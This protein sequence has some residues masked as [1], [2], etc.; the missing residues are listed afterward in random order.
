MVRGVLGALDVRYNELDIPSQQ[1]RSQPTQ[2]GLQQS[3]RAPTLG[4]YAH[5]D[6]RVGELKDPYMTFF[7]MPDPPFQTVDD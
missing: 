4:N 2:E 7:E 6:I 3:R 1:G 5:G